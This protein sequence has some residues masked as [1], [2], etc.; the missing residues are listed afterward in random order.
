MALAQTANPQ[1]AIWDVH[2]H[3]TSATGDTPEERMAQLIRYMDRMGIERVML[4]L[5]YPLVEDPAPQQ[6]REE[7]NQVLRCHPALA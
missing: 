6:L 5:G 7:N 4:S 3:I 1:P 2:C